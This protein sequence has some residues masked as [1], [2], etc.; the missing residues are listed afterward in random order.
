MTKTPRF[1]MT[2]P[3]GLAE[4]IEAYRAGRG[5]KTTV[6]A[7]VEL[8]EAGLDA[9]FEPVGGG[10]LRVTKDY[11]PARGETLGALPRPNAA[12]FGERLKKR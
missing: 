11:T 8:L 3:P 4:R 9:L 7:H 10:A 12:K 6:S 1:I 2:M 5:L